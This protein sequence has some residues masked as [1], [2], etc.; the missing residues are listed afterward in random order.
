MPPPDFS[1]SPLPTDRPIRVFSAYGP[2][3]KHLRHERFE[4]VE[5]ESEA[6]VMWHTRHV[7]DYAALAERHPAKRVNQVF[8]SN[9]ISICL[10]F[11]FH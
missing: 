6:D 1:P 10:S 5:D 4:V 7:K 8:K 9:F 11:E 3:N 2:I